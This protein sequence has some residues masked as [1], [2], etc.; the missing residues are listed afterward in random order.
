M[1][2]GFRFMLSQCVHWIMLLACCYTQYGLLCYL[3]LPCM[4]LLLSVLCHCW[5]GHLICKIVPYMTYYVF[6]RMLNHTSLLSQ[7]VDI[8]F[9][10]PTCTSNDWTSMTR[11]PKP[12]PPTIT[13]AC[14]IF[15][16]LLYGVNIL[17]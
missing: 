1:S 3:A 13:N 8:V 11:W 10:K 16:V 6:R 2:L 12:K 5:L 7:P 15:F 17:I 9:S 14:S 4:V